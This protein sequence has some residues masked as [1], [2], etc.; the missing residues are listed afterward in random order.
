MPGLGW[1]HLKFDNFK[2]FIDKNTFIRRIE[3]SNYGE[4]FLN[5]DLC[6]IIRYAA[7][8]KISLSIGNGANLN[9]ASDEVLE[10]LVRAKV[11]VL[12]VSIDGLSQEAYEKYRVGGSVENVLQNVEKI[13]LY[14]RRYRSSW[15][16]MIWQY[17]IFGHN[18]HEIEE[19]R[20]KSKELNMKFITQ[21]SWNPGWSPTKNAAF[22]EK[23][24]RGIHILKTDTE[25]VYE[26]SEFSACFQMW[27]SPQINSDGKLLGCC[28][29]HH[30]G[31]Y[32]NVFEEGYIN[33]LEG[34][35]FTYA[36]QMLQ[37]KVPAR[38]DIP[39]T[40]CHKYKAMKENNK[41][42][43]PEEIFQPAGK[44]AE[45]NVFSVKNRNTAVPEMTQTS[46]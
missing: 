27:K 20:A 5:P 31:D 2:N 24:F 9:H 33:V 32:G 39:C 45:N 17:V 4:V 23:K 10:Q 41:W 34:E 15:P 28:E 1:E 6:K 14:K 36:K 7:K 26:Y 40:S 16:E 8:R 19:A 13:N 46:H 12:K 25:T 3:L 22:M 11:K 37:G 30:W 42:F 35:R 18:E 29:N 21:L 38:N 44:S 43:D